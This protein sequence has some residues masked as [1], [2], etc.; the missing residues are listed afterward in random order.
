MHVFA[1]YR[2]QSTRI[3]TRNNSRGLPFLIATGTG[4]CKI[5]FQEAHLLY[6]SP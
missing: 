2:S 3:N 6:L 1:Q 4:V 5:K